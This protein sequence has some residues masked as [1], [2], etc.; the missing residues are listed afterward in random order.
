M[1]RAVLSTLAA[2]A[3]LAVVR[4]HQLLLLPE[5]FFLVDGKENQWKPVA[6][7]E[8]QKFNTSADFN[9]WLKAKGYAN[10]RAMMDDEKLYHVNDD[11]M[12][13]CGYTDPSYESQPIPTTGTIRSTGYTHDGPC[14][15]WIDSGDKKTL[16]MSGKNCHAEFPGKTHKLDYSLC[17]GE[18]T[19]RWY[20]MGLRYLKK[21]WS[22]Q[23]YKNCVALSDNPTVETEAPTTK[24]PLAATKAPAVT[25]KAPAATTKAPAA[26]PK[27][28]AATTKAPA[29]T[30]K[31]P[32][33]TPKAPA[34]TT[35]A[36][37]TGSVDGEGS[38]DDDASTVTLP[39]TAPKCGMATRSLLLTAAAML[40][41]A[42]SADAH[43]AVEVPKPNWTVPKKATYWA[44][45]SFLEKN[46]VKTSASI[47]GFMK[48]KGY[49]TLRALMDDSKLYKVNSN[50][51]NFLCG[52]TDPTKG[53]QDIPK[54]STMRSTG[55]THVGP[56]E[57]W[58]DDERVIAGDNCHEQ[59]SSTTKVD[60]SNCKG[61]CT[62]RWYWLGLRFL[63]KKWSWQVYKNCIALTGDGPTISEG[64]TTTYRQTPKGIFAG[65]VVVP[66]ATSK[67]PSNATVDDEGDSKATSKPT[68]PPN[69]TP[70]A[71]PKA[72]K[73]PTTT[74]AAVPKPTTSTT[75]KCKVKGSD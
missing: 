30:T 35:K 49:T 34:A 71:T 23:V 66:G 42:G 73:A 67:A 52:Y 48:E 64:V 14:E 31:A 29:A 28:P 62:M 16:A 3:A 57:V 9:G 36:P 74:P 20:W 24:A 65:K 50:A 18:C 7:L 40:A 56:C 72:T 61:E 70:A 37:A 27:A 25:T 47:D 46:G 54:D 58:I 43:Q 55:Y 44:P 68:S 19:L 1:P 22:W 2:A 59:V 5:P 32:A 6:F 63:K 75:S 26:T 11:A 60:Y 45:L 69:K 21:K 39:T 38:N 13:L 53:S 10:L 17:K 8:H 15:V 4:A 12:F 51:D 33:A 41:L